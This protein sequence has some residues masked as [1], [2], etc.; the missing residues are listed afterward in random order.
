VNF[1]FILYI[2][3]SLWITQVNSTA[4]VTHYI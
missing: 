1:L 3:I 4:V 2:F